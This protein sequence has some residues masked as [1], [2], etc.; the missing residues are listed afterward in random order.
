MD[1]KGSV[2]IIVCLMVSGCSL[3]GPPIPVTGP[4]LMEELA[5]E[6]KLARESVQQCAVG[7]VG[8]NYS[9]EVTAFELTEAAVAACRNESNKCV[10]L[11][12]RW[13]RLDAGIDANPYV[14]QRRA[15]KLANDCV[16]D[17]RG[18]AIQAIVATRKSAPVP[19]RPT[20]SRTG[21]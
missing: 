6:V 18:L 11:T 17:A 20:A 5:R 2:V 16:E 8:E 21:A 14:V 1:H 10:Q 9:S 12:S 7:Y 4:S 15:D 3:F 19:K 13:V